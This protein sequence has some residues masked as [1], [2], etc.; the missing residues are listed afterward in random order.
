[1]PEKRPALGRGLSVL[2]PDVPPPSVASETPTEVDLDRLEPNRDQPRGSIDDGKLDELA[3][4]IKSSGII[5]PIVVR[6]LPSGTYEIVAGER[7]WRAAQ[8]AGLLKVPVVVRD[9]PEDKRLELALIENVQRED[10][11]PIEEARAYR[12]LADQFGLTQE[13]IAT[14]V[15][16]DRATVANYLRLLTLPADVQADVVS[17]A[18][19]MGHARALAALP[20]ASAQRRAARDVVRRALSVRDTELQVKRLLGPPIE[21]QPPPPPDVHT[22]AAADRLRVALG[23]PVE[24]VR[25]GTGGR[26]VVTFTSERELQR[27]FEQLSEGR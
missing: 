27:L 18:L 17:G 26:I 10:L 2:I 20:D 3:Q 13:A 4:S 23:T 16:K 8:R 1:M 11:N 15:G 9:V 22:K 14:A 12:R 7:R 24:I 19:T 6:H 21:R 5:Q 25:R